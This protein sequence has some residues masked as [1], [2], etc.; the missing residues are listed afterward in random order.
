MPSQPIKDQISAL[1]SQEK[2]KEFIYKT[3]LENGH[4]LDEIQ[5]AFES[6][7]LENKKDDQ[8]KKVINIV[9]AIGILFVAA[10]I[11]SFIASNWQA[12]AAAAKVTVILFFML[13]FYAVGWYLKE[14]TAYLRTGEGLILL[15]NIVYGA[16]IFLVAQIFNVRADWPDG[17]I[18]WMIGTVF[19]ALFTGIY[20]LF[21]LALPLGLVALGGY[22]FLIF[23]RFSRF[24]PFL[25][26]SPI[27]LAAATIVTFLAGWAMSQSIKGKSQ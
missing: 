23:S 14:K 5:S 10:G 9:I 15:G 6:F 12:M 11:F 3:L 25:L 8:Q 17:F 1:I 21:Y 13:L 26:T 22:P 2:S 19:M 27:L 24:N 4:S 20:P 18:L 7:S 16:G